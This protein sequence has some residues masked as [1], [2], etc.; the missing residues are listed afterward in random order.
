[1]DKRGRAIPVNVAEQHPMFGQKN[2]S[3]ASDQVEGGDGKPEQR[4]ID[5]KKD[6]E[7]DTQKA[8]V[9]ANSG[10]GPPFRSPDGAEPQNLKAIRPGENYQGGQYQKDN[11]QVQSDGAVTGEIVDEGG[12]RGAEKMSMD[13]AKDVITKLTTGEMSLNQLPD[14]VRNKMKDLLGEDRFDKLMELVGDDV[15]EGEFSDVDD[16]SAAEGDEDQVVEQDIEEETEEVD[17]E[18][19]AKGDEAKA[20]LDEKQAEEMA[21]LIAVNKELQAVIAELMANK[22]DVG[23]AES[24]GKKLD[25]MF[26]NLVNPPEGWKNRMLYLVVMAAVVAT[27]ATVASVAAATMV[28]VKVAGSASRGGYH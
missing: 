21:K 12:E 1:M 7:V 15:I 24:I 23:I 3:G 22:D 6:S 25:E 8:L 14:S 11:E 9:L 20:E 19:D 10:T 26:A 13:E 27:V 28:T 16:E 2:E 17:A 18:D 5:V 4:D